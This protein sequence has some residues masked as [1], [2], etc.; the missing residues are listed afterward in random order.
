MSKR[1]KTQQNTT[2]VIHDPRIIK[3]LWSHDVA[4]TRMCSSWFV[5]KRFRSRDVRGPSAPDS[6]VCDV[7]GIACEFCTYSGGFGED[8]T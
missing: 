4:G 8:P 2:A 1:D 5:R 3:V 6:G 7:M